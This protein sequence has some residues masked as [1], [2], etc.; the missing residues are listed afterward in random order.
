MKTL[1]LLL[2]LACLSQADIKCDL[3]SGTVDSAY[4]KVG[5]AALKGIKFHDDRNKGNMRLF[6]CTCDDDDVR[7]KYL[8][9][10]TKEW[11]LEKETK[12]NSEF[13]INKKFRDH[14][15]FLPAFYLII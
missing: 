10:H 2:W 11:E 5:D 6:E 4:N 8:Q 14:F 12:V 7:N 15:F 3:K 9:L 13:F 1:V